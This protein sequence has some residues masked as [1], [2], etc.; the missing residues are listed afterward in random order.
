MTISS[1]GSIS[2]SPGATYNFT[3]VTNA[4]FLKEI[5]GLGHAGKLSP[6]QQAILT[7]SA[8]GGDSVPINGP[9][10]STAQALSDPTTH[11]FIAEYQNIDWQLHNTPGSVGA[12]LVDSVLQTMQAYQ[13][14]P[15]EESSPSVSTTA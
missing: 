15:I 8:E 1:P 7:L 3:S 2:G 12:A 11:N 13:G 14:Q 9:G 5:D 4:N 6:D 10:V